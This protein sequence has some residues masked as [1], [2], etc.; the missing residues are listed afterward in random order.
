MAFRHKRHYK[1][2]VG[3]ASTIRCGSEGEGIPPRKAPRACGAGDKRVIGTGFTGPGSH[4]RRPFAMCGGSMVSEVKL[5][6]TIDIEVG[7]QA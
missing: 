1:L 7:P 3:R 2:A 6:T 4:F 5:E